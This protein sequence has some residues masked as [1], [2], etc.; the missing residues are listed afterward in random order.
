MTNTKLRNVGELPEPEY[1]LVQLVAK[2]L[3]LVASTSLTCFLFGETPHLAGLS[4]TEIAVIKGYAVECNV[5]LPE[6][7]SPNGLIHYPRR[8]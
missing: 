3:G 4:Q 8:A 7:R 5:I 1:G 2:R 6:G